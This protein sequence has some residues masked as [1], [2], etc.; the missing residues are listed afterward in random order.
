MQFRRSG[1]V[2]SAGCILLISSAL[3]AVADTPADP[4]APV[5][6]LELDAGEVASTLFEMPCPRT[7]AKEQPSC[8]TQWGLV[9]VAGG[10]EEITG[11]S[12]VPSPG[13]P[14]AGAQLTISTAP[15]IL[16]TGGVRPR[17]GA[18]FYDTAALSR[19][20][21]AGTGVD[22]VAF[23]NVTLDA[24]PPTS[25]AVD[26][27]GTIATFGIFDVAYS[28]ILD[29]HVLGLMGMLTFWQE[30]GPS[31]T[32][33]QGLCRISADGGV[34]F[35][36]TFLSDNSDL[37]VA[38]HGA[39]TVAMRL[40]DRQTLGTA[41]GDM[42]PCT[43]VETSS[44]HY[45]PPLALSPEA[46]YTAVMDEEYVAGSTGTPPEIDEY[47]LG[48]YETDW[49]VTAPNQGGPFLS[50]SSV[51]AA[52]LTANFF[53]HETP[54]AQADFAPDESAVLSVTEDG[55]LRVWSLPG[56]APVGTYPTVEGLPVNAAAFD[57][58]AD[59]ILVALR[60]GGTR[61]LEPST[62]EILQTF[63][64][65]SARFLRAPGNHIVT[66]SP[67]AA[68]IRAYTQNGPHC[69]ADP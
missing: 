52:G 49:L 31:G 56:G 22:P 61:L 41:S 65:P 68:S 1:T 62:G 66:Y 21:G 25:G 48:I 51:S 17:E 37:A 27:P 46:T 24:S 5:F 4:W 43:G 64:D 28:G 67:G 29:L 13:L 53:G 19:S 69:G 58:S 54:I 42:P 15:S 11:W 3:I 39:W 63:P 2:A 30:T 59:C 20:Q 38:R 33:L 36:A 8:T 10:G 40:P 26:I 34:P 18:L 47:V 60:G 32:T 50:A 14:V 57:R 12:L 7:L 55:V 44:I 9:T 35:L 16:P 23:S 45:F 6:D